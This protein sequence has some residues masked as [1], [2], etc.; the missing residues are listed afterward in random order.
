MIKRTV[1]NGDAWRR[2][3]LGDYQLRLAWQA[4]IISLSGA[5]SKLAPLDRPVTTKIR[6]MY[7]SVGAVQCSAVQGGVPRSS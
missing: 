3:G 6:L 5:A 4:G 7:P 2:A 1:K